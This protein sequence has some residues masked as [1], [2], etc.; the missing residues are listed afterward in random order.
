MLAKFATK[1]IIARPHNI[2]SFRVA[3]GKGVPPQIISVAVLFLWFLHTSLLFSVLEI[4][5]PRY[6]SVATPRRQRLCGARVVGR[7][8]SVFIIT[9]QKHNVIARIRNQPVFAFRK[10]AATLLR[11]RVVADSWQSRISLC[12][13]NAPFLFL[14][15]NLSASPVFQFD[16]IPTVVRRALRYYAISS[17]SFG[18][19]NPFSSNDTVL[20]R[21][22]YSYCA[23]N[24]ATSCVAVSSS[25]VVYISTRLPSIS[26]L[27]RCAIIFIPIKVRPAVVSVLNAS[28]PVACL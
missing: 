8:I 19:T 26:L 5:L 23:V 25:H 14:F 18:M 20:F 1:L 24:N 17:N 7:V 13:C 9:N 22:V 15:F 27:S 28:T 12:R 21:F 3:E 6:R 16:W 11:R 10:A 2:S 4:I